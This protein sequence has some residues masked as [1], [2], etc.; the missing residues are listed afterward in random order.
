MSIEVGENTKVII[1]YKTVGFTHGTG[2]KV[3]GLTLTATEATNLEKTKD[4]HE[5]IVNCVET[6]LSTPWN[7]PFYYLKALYP[8]TSVKREELTFDSGD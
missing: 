3:L 6:A 8:I 5:S 2:S 1:M 7:S 4:Q